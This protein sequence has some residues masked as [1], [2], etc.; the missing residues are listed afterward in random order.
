MLHDKLYEK[1]ETY[2]VM[3]TKTKH[4]FLKLQELNQKIS[5]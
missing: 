5:P 4:F 3:I 2:D 1:N